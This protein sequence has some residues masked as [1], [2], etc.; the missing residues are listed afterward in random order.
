[1]STFADSSALVKLYADETG[2]EVVR[3][4][5]VLIVSQIARVE[6]P[7]A[8]WRKQRLGELSPQHARLLSEEF[9]ADFFGTGDDG[10]RFVTVL[11]TAAVLDRAAHLCAVHGLRANDAVQLGSALAVRDVESNCRTV[12]AF[13]A[14]LRRAAAAEGFALQPAQAAV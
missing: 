14:G 12:A 2:P 13:D 10:P 1:M 9:E 11:L 7:G 6:V 3:A 8:L 4:I 5:D